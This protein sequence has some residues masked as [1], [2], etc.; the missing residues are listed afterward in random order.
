MAG[1]RLNQL[2]FTEAD[3]ARL[4]DTAE[5]LAGVNPGLAATVW[6]AAYLATMSDAAIRAYTTSALSH[7]RQME[8]RLEA[9]QTMIDQAKAN[10][11]P[12]FE[13]QA[14]QDAYDSI[15]AAHNRVFN[16]GTDQGYTAP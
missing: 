1:T 10:G 11:A 9:L 3:A 8:T 15:E 13:V 14:L 12:T 7:L 4:N 6:Q 5:A 16:P 2:A